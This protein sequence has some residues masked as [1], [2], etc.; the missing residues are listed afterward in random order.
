MQRRRRRD[1]ISAS[2]FECS[3]GGGV[4]TRSWEVSPAP[5]LPSS[6]PYAAQPPPTSVLLR[7]TQGE[8]LG[9]VPRPDGV[10]RS[11]DRCRV[12][13]QTSAP[14]RVSRIR[15]WAHLVAAQRDSEVELSILRIARQLGPAAGRPQW[16][17][18]R[19]PKLATGPRRRAI[20]PNLSLCVG[21]KVGV[22]P[23]SFASVDRK[24]ALVPGVSQALACGG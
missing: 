14:L 17:L 6:S 13:L 23:T 22:G 16:L 5:Q 8:E 15:S 24:L 12:P 1:G 4:R 2:Q 18:Q 3:S 7:P 10:L 21:R 20:A 11:P 19:S 9:P